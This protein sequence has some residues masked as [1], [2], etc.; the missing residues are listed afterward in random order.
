[1]A[2]DLT[3]NGTGSIAAIIGVLMIAAFVASLYQVIAISLA[4]I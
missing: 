3:R 4:A 2:M 1:M